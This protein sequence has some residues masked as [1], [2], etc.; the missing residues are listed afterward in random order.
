MGTLL[1]AS[2]QARREAP[3]RAVTI[4][5]T[6]PRDL[7]RWDAQIQ[8]MLRSGELRIRKIR[9]DTLIAG[10]IIARADQYHR[11]VRVF[12]GD[13]V[14]QLDGGVVL[15]M[16]GKVYDGVSIDTSPGIDAERAR[17]I[18]Q[19]VSGAQLAPDRQ[20]ELVILPRQT[21]DILA[22]RLS[23]ATRS[24]I[25]QY[26][27]DARDGSIA[28]EYS[29][30]KRQAAVGRAR[31]VLGDSK[32]ISVSGSSGRFTARDVLRPPSIRTLDMKGSLDRTLTILNGFPVLAGDVASDDDNDWTDGATDDA[33][34]YQGWTYDYYF[35]R[36]NRH[37]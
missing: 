32:K 35:K 4:A 8:A 24:D 13:V 12:G 11:G 26:F 20:P 27:V 31:G 17:E 18:V 5:P 3:A 21:G 7:R 36:F 2:A 10:R 33:H 34:V 16:F 14:R 25:R 15:S 30:L 37:G 22:W 1:H 29:D 23:A 28:F 6:S 19:A 9:D